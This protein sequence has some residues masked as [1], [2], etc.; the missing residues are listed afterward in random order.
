MKNLIY[1]S[2]KIIIFLVL[3]YFYFSIQNND[4]NID[5][6]NKNEIQEMLTVGVA[7]ILGNQIK[8]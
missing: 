7:F 1:N 8:L 2:I 5:F 4:F 3:I 6:W